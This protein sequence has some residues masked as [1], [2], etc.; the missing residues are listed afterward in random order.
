MRPHPRLAETDPTSPRAWATC[1][2]CGFLANLYK[3][4]WQYEWRGI[5]LQN[6]RHLVCEYCVDDPQRQLGTIV[7]PPDPP[8]IINARVEQYSVDENPV[9]TRYTM[10]GIPRAVTYKPFP[11]LRIV[12]TQGLIDP[13]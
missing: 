4:Q 9:S 13:S 7:I 6:T 11:M 3:L 5:Q 8:P 12:S 1:E 10:N 2:R